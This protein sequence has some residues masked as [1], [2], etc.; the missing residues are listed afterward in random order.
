[1][2]LS[3]S[4]PSPVS[5]PVDKVRRIQTKWRKGFC[6]LTTKKLTEAF[7]ATGP[8]IQHVKSIRCEC[9]AFFKASPLL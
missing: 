7:D 8:T 1:M 4:A 2:M 5:Y 9:P 6:H 3:L